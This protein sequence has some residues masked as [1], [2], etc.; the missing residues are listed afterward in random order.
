MKILHDEIRFPSLIT[1]TPTLL[2]RHVLSFFSLPVMNVSK[3]R[4]PT[5]WNLF[6]NE[7][8]RFFKLDSH[9]NVKDSA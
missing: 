1:M 8:P 4:N 5:V 3:E 9:A 7:C 2:V 6:Q